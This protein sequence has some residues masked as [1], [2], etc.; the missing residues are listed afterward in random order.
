ML[1]ILKIEA[2]MFESENAAIAFRLDC[3]MQLKVS[4]RIDPTFSK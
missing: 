2:A 4:E 3:P 1:R